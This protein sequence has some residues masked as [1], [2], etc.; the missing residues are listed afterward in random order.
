MKRWMFE[1]GL[2]LIKFQK[3]LIT[4]CIMIVSTNAQIWQAPWSSLISTAENKKKEYANNF[5]STVSSHLRLKIHSF[6][7]VICVLPVIW[8]TRWKRTLLLK[9]KKA[10]KPFLIFPIYVVWKWMPSRYGW[11][12]HKRKYTGR[13][14]L[15][16]AAG[17]VN[18]FFWLEH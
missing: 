13:V 6:Y 7:D 1:A 2:T 16:M 15:C 18:C 14:W 9:I 4:N 12:V 11:D 10:H 3:C 8:S 17:R 5:C